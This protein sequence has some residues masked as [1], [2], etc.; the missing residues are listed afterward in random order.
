M[1]VP[2][3]LRIVG[4]A[5]IVLNGRMTLNT[6]SALKLISR[7]NSSINLYKINFKRPIN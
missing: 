7:E 1:R 5:L 6:L 3:Y 2:I 4:N